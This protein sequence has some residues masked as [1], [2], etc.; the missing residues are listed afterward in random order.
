[1]ASTYSDLKFQLMTTGENNTT[2]GNVTNLNLGTAIEEAIAESATVTFASGPETI[3]LTDTNASQVARHLRLDLG[4]TSGGAQNLIVPTIE[5]PY[6][7][8]N[9]TADII[10]VKTSAGTGIAVPSGKTMW[11]YA[12]GTNVVDVVTH[13]T[14]L[15]LGTALSATQGGTGLSSLGTNVAT[16]L[17]TPS[18]ANLLAAITD[19]TGTGALVFGTSP[20]LVTPALGTPASGVATNLTGLPISSGVSGLGTNV[21]TFLGTPSSANLLA[22][23][24]DE[25]GTG[26]AVFATS[27]TLV[28]PL[29]GTPTSGVLTNCTGLPPAGVTAPLKTALINFIIDGGG[30]V[31]GTGIKGDLEVPFACTITAS[32]IVADVSGSAVVDI[33]KDTYANFPPVDGDSITAS[34][35]PILSS[36]IK[37]QDTTLTGWTTS[38]AA[39]DWLRFNLD[40]V[41]TCKI[42]TVTLTVTKT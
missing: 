4:G 38:I 37:N 24:T 22:A 34:A 31:P 42:I 19:E 29:L 7:I 15:T 33:W 41:T 2:W 20:T 8:N 12:D 32:R 17:G 18:S 28:T 35:T 21:A 23:L 36:A 26:V 10:T 11:V 6:L 30:A 14:S 27:P 40:S 13:L 25:T 16:F 39:G 5:K 3:S 9:G 1:M